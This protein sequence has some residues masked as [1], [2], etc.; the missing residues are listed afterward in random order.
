M[1]HLLNNLSEEEKNSIRE[2]HEG[3][4]KLD[5]SRFR[6]LLEGKSGNVKPLV[7]QEDD[8]PRINLRKHFDKERELDEDDNEKPLN[9]IQ[10]HLLKKFRSNPNI[11]S[12]Y[13]M[14]DEEFYDFVYNELDH[15]H[16]NDMFSPDDS[17]FVDDEE[18]ED[19]GFAQHDG[20]FGGDD[21]E[22]ED[23]EELD[24]REFDDLEEDETW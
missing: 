5:T 20:D 12:D 16:Y 22:F 24:L 4:I 15:E 23:E 19:L 7:E 3:G 10:K 13:G 2:Q 8:Y 1:K 17:R 11:A 14:S 18:E 21:S 6:T 9:I